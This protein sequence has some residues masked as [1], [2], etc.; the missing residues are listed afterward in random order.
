MSRKRIAVAVAAVLV[1]GGIAVW[2]FARE[3]RV[4]A[5]VAQGGTWDGTIC[6]GARPIILEREELKRG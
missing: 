2:Q 3:R 1:L 6:R 5:C 4:A